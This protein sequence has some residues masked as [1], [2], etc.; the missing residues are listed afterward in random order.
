MSNNQIHEMKGPYDS[1]SAEAAGAPSIYGDTN[2][3]QVDMLRLGKKQEFKARSQRSPLTT[4][5]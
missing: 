4:Y 3:D 2:N 5:I 1:S